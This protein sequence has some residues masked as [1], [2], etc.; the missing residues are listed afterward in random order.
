MTDL[1]DLKQDL[2]RLRDEVRL[3]VHLGSMEARQEWDELETQ[4]ERF[5]DR[6]GL[7][8]S[9]ENVG[10][11]LELLGAELKRGYQRLKAALRD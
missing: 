8:D 10:D 3:R 4:W 9:A 1:D 7:E 6:A 11:A 5:S 2:K